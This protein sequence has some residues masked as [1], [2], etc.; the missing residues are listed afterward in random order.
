MR[1]VMQSYRT[2][3]IA[4]AEVPAP[5]AKPGHLLVRTMTSI[6][7][8]GTE[9]QILEFARRGL[10]G[11]A[12]A[13]PDLVRQI[14]AKV[15]TEGM[16]EAWRQAM[17]R[18]DI[19]VPLGYSSSGRVIAIGDGVVEFTVGDRVACTGSG[20]AGHAEVVS[21]PVNLCVRIPDSVDNEAAAFA[22]LGGIALEAMRMAH[23]SLGETIAVVGLGLLGQIAVQL[24]RAAG[25]IVLGM[26][27]DARR[28]EMAL[29]AGASA[30]ASGPRQFVEVCRTWT[31]GHGVDAVMIL[32]ATPSNEPLERAAE[33][34]R[35]R[36]RI[37]VT[38]LVG[39]E[40][41]RK[42]FYEKELELVISRAWGPGLYDRPYADSGLDYPLAYARWTAKRNL[43]A[44]LAQLAAGTVKVSH[45]ITHRFPMEQA[46][47][48]YRLILQSAERFLAVMLTYPE[49]P[50]TPLTRTILL[51]PV[52]ILG[53]PGQVTVGVIGA[54]LF[55]HGTLLPALR[56]VPKLVRRGVA[57]TTGLTS[58]E[59]AKKFGFS[60][61]TTDY[62][63]LLADPEIDVVLI[64][65]RH[66][67][68]ARL[69]VEALEA[70][71][72]V[73]VEKPLALTV[74]ELRAIVQAHRQA[75]KMLLVG[76][77][78]R[79]APLARWLRNR[80]AA[81]RA[82]IT[83]HCTVNA[84]PVPAGSWIYDPTEG[85]GRVASEMGHFVDLVQFLTGSPPVRVFAERAAG[86]GDLRDDIAVTLRMADGAVGTIT[87]AAGGDKR[88]PRERIEVF[89]GGA[90]GVL[91]NFRAA[92]FTCQG[93]IS[94]ARH[95][96][97]VDRG[98]AAEIEAVVEAVRSGSAPVPI[99]DYVYATLTTLGI[100]ESLRTGRAVDIDVSAVTG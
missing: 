59:A 52:A 63:Q 75:G 64:L 17:A 70:G 15:R 3:E 95:W 49:E 72:H 56:R 40:V 39:L 74:D 88:F 35:E 94:R 34:C 83:V 6:V 20:Y 23:I 98:Y 99:A 92:R 22:A 85:G 16:L 47:D 37:V 14:I 60:Y 38:G 69:V 10:V 68:H 96:L 67:S 65:T 89:G 61:C 50:G 36:G 45:L 27:L 44:F 9:K 76:F 11:K 90:A 78:R 84:G 77:N 62:Q 8:V 13:R 73:F 5:L 57:T 79:F 19:P 41:P 71:K 81:L 32:A 54:G 46:T 82:P 21:V 100:E 86:S 55:A 58:H 30:V 51:T 28:T 4:I 91:D 93:R 80:C 66:G 48:A 1:Q 25:C 31:A 53:T 24:A 18:L 26:D 87:Y 33:I 2:G 12:L 97:G 7:S 29:Q 42:P 43:E